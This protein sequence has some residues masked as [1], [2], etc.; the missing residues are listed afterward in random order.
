M[1]DAFGSLSKMTTAPKLLE[2]IEE[3]DKRRFARLVYEGIDV[4][5]RLRNDGDTLLFAAIREEQEGTKKMTVAIST[6]M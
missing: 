5:M 1:T 2:A 4:N 6:F 3:G